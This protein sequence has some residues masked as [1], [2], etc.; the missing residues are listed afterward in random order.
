MADPKIRAE[1]DNIANTMTS[2]LTAVGSAMREVRQDKTRATLAEQAT[3]WVKP[4]VALAGGIIN[5]GRRGRR[6]HHHGELMTAWSP[7]FSPPTPSSPSAPRFSRRQGVAGPAL[8][9]AGQGL[10]FVPRRPGRIRRIAAHGAASRGRR[11]NRLANRD[12]G[13]RRLARGAAG[14]RRRRPLPDHVVRGALDRPG[15]GP[16][17]RARRFR[18]VRPRTR[19]ATSRSPA[20]SWR[21]SRRPG[22]WFRPS[23]MTSTADPSRLA[24]GALRGHIGGSWTHKCASDFAPFSS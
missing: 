10:L 5:G 3:N 24:S 2:I 22:G 12:I 7:R 14:S 13:P 18:M 23:S 4:L 1:F 21:S 9:L 16:E 17:R 6:R 11:G 8:A 19:S 15:A 20:A